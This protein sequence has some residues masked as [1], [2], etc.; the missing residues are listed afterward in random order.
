MVQEAVAEYLQERRQATATKIQALQ[1]GTRSRI[2]NILREVM[3]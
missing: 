1:D 2:L 3:Q